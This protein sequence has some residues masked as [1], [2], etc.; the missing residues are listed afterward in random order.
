MENLKS[1]KCPVMHGASSIYETSINKWWPKSLN[2]DI[3]H[4]HEKQILTVINLITG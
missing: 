2:L 4:Q 1:G 3:L